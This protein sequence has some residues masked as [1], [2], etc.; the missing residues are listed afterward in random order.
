M[1]FTL[2]WIFVFLC[3]PE[4]SA[5]SSGGTTGFEFLRSEVGARQSG[6][7]GAF[8]A[9]DGDL[10]GMACNPASLAGVDTRR[11]SFAYV[12]HLLD[13]Q[14]G[15]LGMAAPLRNGGRLGAALS[16]MSYGEF[17]WTDET[18][19]STGSSTPG[20]MLLSVGYGA[21]TSK[22][23]SY[24]ASVRYMRQTI[25]DYSADAA[26]FNAGILYRIP[27]QQAT[28][29]LAVLNVGKGLHAFVDRVERVPTSVRAGVTKRLAHL[30]LMLNLDVQKFTG[31]S[32][33]FGDGLYW[34]LGGEFTV[35]SRLLLRWGYASRG[36]DNRMGSSGTRLSGLSLG[37]GILAGRL[38]MDYGMSNYG[39]LGTVHQFGITAD[40]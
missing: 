5:A 34:I 29:G 25:Q 28:V 15:F 16:Y 1:R 21:R 36:S 7:G 32:G 8:V 40:F 22:T 39:V 14:A 33:S 9:L 13:F 24:G 17:E 27:S 6:M 26:V 11:A 37:L 31:E 19:G 23:L 3:L 2:K 4:L 18:G 12:N 35:S 20:D 38:S 30:P 10:Y